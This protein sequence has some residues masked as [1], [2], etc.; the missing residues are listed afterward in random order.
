MGGD[1]LAFCGPIAHGIDDYIRDAIEANE[2]RREKLIV[3]LETDG[4]YIEIAERIANIFRRYYEAVEFVVPNFAMSAGTVLVMSGDAIHMDYFSILGPIDPQTERPDGR[5]V[6]AL[7]YLAKYADLIKKSQ[8]GTLTTAELTFLISK[9]DPAE[10]YY[11]EQAKELSDSLLKEWLVKYK[12]KNWKTTATR[13]KKVTRQMKIKRAQEIGDSLNNTKKW[14]SHARGIS[15][16][17]LRNDLNLQIEDFG[18]KQELNK[19]VREYYK[20]L[21][22][23]MTK[24]AHRWVIHS[25]QNYV[26]L[27][28]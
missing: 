19:C 3:I 13:G 26:P 28:G 22:D 21:R 24:R 8:K 27:G 15:M 6:P 20:L 4:G 14:S 5:F 23:Y 18:A 25:H 9:F 1:A 11:Y 16:Q 12:F 17:V 2:E 7:G 10:L